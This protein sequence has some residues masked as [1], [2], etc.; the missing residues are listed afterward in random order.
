MTRIIVFDTNVLISA[1]LAPASPSS[2]ALRKALREDTV[3]YSAS[4][5]AE[6]AEKISLPRFNKYQP[7]ARRLVFYY[8]YEM[9][10]YPINIT[11]EIKA[12]RDPKD[13]QFLELAKSANAD[14]IVTKDNDLLILHPFEDIPILNVTQFLNHFF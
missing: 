13:D 5:L 11:H 10:A 4:T 14:C 9:K 8:D 12:C 3:V 6:L 2:T 7:L 1:L